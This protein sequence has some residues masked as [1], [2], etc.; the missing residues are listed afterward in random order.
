MRL[1]IVEDN[2]NL[3]ELLKVSFRDFDGEVV[4]A[5]GGKEAFDIFYESCITNKR[6]DAVLTD[7]AMAGIDGYTLAALI[8]VIEGAHCRTRLA[9]MT[10]HGKEFR[11][12]SL[13]EKYGIEK[14]YEKPESLVGLPEEITKW[15]R[16]N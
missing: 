16:G 6:F 10:A 14:Y 15:L 5:E 12:N 9:S 11:N 7:L 3:R 2:E 4:F 1:L 8:R 13:L